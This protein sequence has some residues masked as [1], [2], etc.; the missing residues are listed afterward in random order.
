MKIFE[1]GF[2]R[3]VP[4]FIDRIFARGM[5]TQ[6]AAFA[7]AVLVLWLGAWALL[8][9]AGITLNEEGPFEILNVY[10]VL[11]NGVDM[12]PTL[13]PHVQIITIL[14][15]F[16]GFVILSGGLIAVCSNMVERRVE[17]FQ[18]G[19]VSYYHEN[20]FLIVGCGEAL[21]GLI[22]SIH[23]GAVGSLGRGGIGGRYAYSGE[24][25]VI[26][27]GG[28]VE[29]ERER[30]LAAIQFEDSSRRYR[31]RIYFYYNAM[32]TEDQ[33]AK[34]YPERAK[35][36]F[37]LGDRESSV[38][39]DVRNLSCM[40][41][42]S[43]T[44]SRRAAQFPRANPVSVF[45]EIDRPETFT[46]LQKVDKIPIR[47]ETRI[48][49]HP[50]SLHENYAR[51]LWGLY[52]APNAGSAAYRPLDYL[53]I[54]EDS[55]RRV[56]L[57]V[58]GLSGA[59]TALLLE[60]L[61]ICH[62][63]NFETRGV[64]TKITVVDRDFERKRDAFFAQFPHLDQVRDVELEFLAE[65][66]ESPRVRAEIERLARDPDCL[67]TVAVCIDDPEIALAVGLNFP[68]AL[69]RYEDGEKPHGNSVLIR[70]TALGE[71]ANS[72]DGETKRYRYVRVFGTLG[73]DFDA[74]LLNDAIPM[75]IHY[76]YE[77][78]DYK[79]GSPLVDPVAEPT[80][81]ESV[82]EMKRR[83]RELAEYKRWS[84]RFQA[85]MFRTYLRTIGFDVV[86][87]RESSRD[88]LHRVRNLL[89]KHRSVLA[90][91]EHRRW[92]AEKTLSGFVAGTVKND[93]RRVHCDIRAAEE[94]SEEKRN[95]SFRPVL[96]LP[97]L[98]AGDHWEIV[99][100]ASDEDAVPRG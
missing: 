77:T 12:D 83:W 11:L 7:V 79:N 23:S 26:V 60:A 48:D 53:P 17:L 82:S 2:L 59:G 98:L 88:V 8:C 74:E 3:G 72:V 85:E 14:I 47:S 76:D 9:L 36:I 10:Y 75:R 22:E 31:D 21:N 94:L 28:D 65:N 66:A 58:V 25:I 70:Q 61:R 46:I 43:L 57:V 91:M 54:T 96:N 78:F 27:T 15:S 29:R 24:D 35:V 62:Y 1:S 81:E 90:K 40:G 41:T 68:E 73:E 100:L 97:F 52:G 45:V 86:R 37:I 16:A 20:H 19:L 13:E 56:H 34:L 5:L 99:P 89:W 18:K 44:V 55:D 51:K 4:A 32:E 49:P 84:N 64:K 33:I 67:L 39:R 30:V 42:L 63:A 38:G 50:F 87:S 6:I 92:C 71:L 95:L 80:S 93:V 69:Y